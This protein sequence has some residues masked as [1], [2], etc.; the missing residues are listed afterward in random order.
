MR[1][2][3]ILDVL[4]LMALV[5]DSL[6]VVHAVRTTLGLGYTVIYLCSRGGAL[7]RLAVPALAQVGIT[8]QY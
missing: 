4:A 1:A 6:E 5:V 8:L 2:A 3:F 7:L